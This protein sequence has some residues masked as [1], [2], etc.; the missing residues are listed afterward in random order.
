MSEN[1][2][3]I[4]R[5]KNDE[6]DLEQVLKTQMGGYT[7][8]SVQEYISQLKR[9]QQHATEAFNTEMQ[10]LLNDKEKLQDENSQ[11][12]N[13]LTKVVTDYKVLSDNVASVKVGETNL[14]MDDVIQL[15]GHV[16][17]LEKEKQE[18]QAKIKQ[19][20]KSVEQKQHI[21]GEKNRLIDQLKQESIMY[22]E[23]LSG[24]RTEKERLQK[25]VTE[26]ATE[27]DQFQGEIH[28][29]KSVIS[30]G[31]IA[32]L[33]TRIDELTGDLEKLN[34]ELGIKVQ[35]QQNYIAQIETL[36]QQ[37]NT[38]RG[39][40]EELKVSLEKAMDQNEKMQA[41]NALLH[42]QLERC[43]KENLEFLRAQ[44]DLQVQV[45]ILSR[46]L[47]TEKLR[48]IVNGKDEKTSKK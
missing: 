33:N 43:M 37:G 24:E 17:V 30:D 27:I 14:T 32:Q 46:K 48:N 40:N 41:E 2:V 25:M 47:D 16:R 19:G 11:L 39:V 26:Q 10:N 4:L 5:D 29:L 13:K 20:E 44:S 38:V 3:D 21:I 36:T 8:K 12:K 1:V 28:F 18:A 23:M 22:Q 7:K 31:N 42:K 15:R 45:A 35:E 9:Q 34:A 6:A